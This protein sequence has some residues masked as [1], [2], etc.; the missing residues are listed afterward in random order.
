M[1]PITSLTT[2]AHLDL[3]AKSQNNITGIFLHPCGS[4]KTDQ[5]RALRT[6][7]RFQRNGNATYECKSPP[8]VN[9]VDR[10]I[11][12]NSPSCGVFGHSLQTSSCQ[13]P[14]TQSC[15]LL[16]PPKFIKTREGFRKE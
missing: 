5:P 4:A 9:S 2:S 1:S 11:N 15:Y 8:E 13:T 7:S 14:R 6:W 12:N 3:P 10:K 16:P